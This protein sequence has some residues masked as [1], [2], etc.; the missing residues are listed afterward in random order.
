MKN[1]T[2]LAFKIIFRN[3]IVFTHV[4]LQAPKAILLDYQKTSLK[5]TVI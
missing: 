1:E 2:I 4:T 5:T 3:N